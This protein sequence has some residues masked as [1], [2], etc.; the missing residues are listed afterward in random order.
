MKTFEKFE[1]CLNI[2]KMYL[3]IIQKYFQANGGGILE[4][5]NQALDGSHSECFIS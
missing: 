3:Q 2:G 5:L 1:N 4:N